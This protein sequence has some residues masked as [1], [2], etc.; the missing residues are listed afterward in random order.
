[1]QT[2]N[3]ESLFNSIH[4]HP[5]LIFLRFKGIYVVTGVFQVLVSIFILF[6]LELGSVMVHFY[7]KGNYPLW[8]TQISAFKFCSIYHFLFL[9]SWV[10]KVLQFSLI[11]NKG[12]CFPDG[13]TVLLIYA[14][15]VKGSRNTAIPTNKIIRA[16]Y[17]YFIQDNT[18]IIAITAFQTSRTKYLPSDHLCL[19]E[20]Q[21][22]LI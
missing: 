2:L 8:Q 6:N 16:H 21:A 20:P 7:K 14:Q 12:R 11:L 4:E 1:M 5:H 19:S 22:S 9:K 18:S 17:K 15:G 10:S 3:S 13:I